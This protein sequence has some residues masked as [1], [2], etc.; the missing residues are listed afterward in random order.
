MRR[1]QKFYLALE[2]I[3]VLLSLLSQCQSRLIARQSVNFMS[4][5]EEDVDDTAM[6]E[7]PGYG[8]EIIASSQAE[9]NLL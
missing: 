2:I 5:L 1:P 8:E 7:G 4:S 3:I 6:E 9:M